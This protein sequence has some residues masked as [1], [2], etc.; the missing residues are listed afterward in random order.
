M[1]EPTNAEIMKAILELGTKVDGIRIE[2]A[3]LRGEVRQMNVRICDVNA[4]L[5]VPIAYSPPEPRRT[6]TG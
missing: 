1:G 6:G 2:L 5:P 4:R 3:E